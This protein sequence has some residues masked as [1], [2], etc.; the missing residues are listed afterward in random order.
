MISLFFRNHTLLTSAE[1]MGV[2]RVEEDNAFVSIDQWIVNH[3]E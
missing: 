2:G 1:V 3:R